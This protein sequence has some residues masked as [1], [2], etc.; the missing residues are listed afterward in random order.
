LI[1]PPD[2]DVVDVQ[3]LVDRS[4]PEAREAVAEVV[5]EIQYYLVDKGERDAWWYAK[6]H[7]TTMADAYS[8]V[9]WRYFMSQLDSEARD[10]TSSLGEFPGFERMSFAVGSLLDDP[11]WLWGYAHGVY[12]F[13]EDGHVVYVGRALG[14]TLGQRLAD[15]LGSTDDPEWAEVVRD[16]ANRIEVF[17][18]DDEWLH[19]A[20]ALEVYL[21]GHLDPR[22]R[23]NR[24][25]E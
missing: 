23:F 22:P 10:F 9:H 6:Y 13:V 1:G 17:T 18:I 11:N 15:Q 24:R 5:K 3:F 2:G 8:K 16:R 14:C 25:I 20:S 4:D 7:T 12:C 21:I 19:L